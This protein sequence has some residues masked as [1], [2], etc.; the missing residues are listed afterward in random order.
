MVHIAKYEFVFSA[1]LTRKGENAEK[2]QG[3]KRGE[4][5]GESGETHGEGGC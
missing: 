1:H 5:Q 2:K 3:K 4:F